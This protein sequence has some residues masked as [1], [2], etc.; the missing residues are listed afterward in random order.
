VNDSSIR[1]RIAQNPFFDGLAQ[2]HIEFL[3]ANARSRD[4]EQD[5]VLF[6]YGEKAD[7]FYV[8]LRGRVVIEVASLEGPPLELQQLDDGA[9][10]GWSWL[11]PP[12]TWTF[13]ARADENTEVLELDG[14]AIRARCEADPNFGYALLKRFS[15]LMSE[16][17]HFARK[18]MMD[19]WRPSGFA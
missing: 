1:A 8:I 6:H 19:E 5:R 4:V 16:R 12:Y 9:I 2:E 10:L 7:H 14:G 18:R 13:Q 11:I 15:S 17:L 3:A